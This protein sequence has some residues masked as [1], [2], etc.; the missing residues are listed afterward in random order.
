MC[1][2]FHSPYVLLH[3]GVGAGGG[4][5]VPAEIAA[6]L[7]ASGPVLNVA[8]ALKLYIPLQ[9]AAPKEGVKRTNDIAYGPAERHRLDVYE[10][11]PRPAGPAPVLIFIH[12][13]AF[14]AG[15][16]STPGSPF[17][18]NIGYYFARHG[19]LTINATYR[20]A[21]KDP[22]P[23]GAADIGAVVRWAREN[24]DTFG[25]DSGRIFLMGHSAGATHAAAYAFM[26]GL[27]PK[28][29]TG[30]LGVILVSGIYDPALEESIPAAF[31]GGVPGNPNR[32]YYGPDTK[33]YPERSILPNLRSDRQ[34]DG[35]LRRARHADDAGRGGRALYCPLQARRPVPGAFV[36]ARPRPHVGG[37]LR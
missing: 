14:A 15:N 3:P 27:H 23:A 32:A 33:L 12:G 6:R 10:P 22:W 20:L 13:G 11:A 30:L 16:K 17:Y 29:G 18:D 28:E 8:Q 31:L 5:G 19:V 9:A 26:K 7:R 4:A 34:D 25:G 24:A 36:A 35:S 1:S 37:I 2:L 21:P